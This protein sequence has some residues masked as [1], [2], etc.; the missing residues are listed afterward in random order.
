MNRDFEDLGGRD[1]Y[2]I[3]GLPPGTN[4]AEVNR[5]FRQLLRRSHPDLGGSH[6]QQV[7]LNLARDVLLDPTRLREYQ[8]RRRKADSE[9]IRRPDRQP[10]DESPSEEAP[11][12]DPFHWESGPGPST[13]NAY[14][15]PP[16]PRHAWY[17]PPGIVIEPSL[18]DIYGHPVKGDPFRRWYEPVVVPDPPH[19]AYPRRGWNGLVFVALLLSPCFPIGLILG[20]VTL[21]QIHQWHQR[22]AV[23]AWLAIAASIVMVLLLIC[24]GLLPELSR[25][26]YWPTP[27]VSGSAHPTR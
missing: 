26:P 10:P 25:T 4:A 23:F 22:G 27:S 14:R 13:A 6:E 9:P 24:A 19:T 21:N 18:T 17:P 16:P 1:P 3:L 7:A 12:E 11:Y 15:A 8:W 5:R 20:L 2:E